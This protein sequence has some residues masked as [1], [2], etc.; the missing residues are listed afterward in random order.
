MVVETVL[1]TF[2]KV[3]DPLYTT[4]LGI[5]FYGTDVTSIVQ[6]IRQNY[7]CAQGLGYRGGWAG[8]PGGPRPGHPLGIYG[9]RKENRLTDA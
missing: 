7:I 5:F 2:V 3:G 6:K 1:V 4:A 8:G 9:I